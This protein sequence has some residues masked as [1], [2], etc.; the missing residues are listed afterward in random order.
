MPPQ[1]LDADAAVALVPEGASILL[2]GF[3]LCGIPENLI[4]ALA[5]RG[6]GDL[7]VMSNNAGVADGGGLCS[8]TAVRAWSAPT[9]GES[10]S[11][12]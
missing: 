8:P 12:A 2:G 4:K 11:R 10:A 1:I 6:T 3:G 9:S 5:R 7:T